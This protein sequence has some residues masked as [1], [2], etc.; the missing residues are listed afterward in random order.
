M[1]VL[2]WLIALLVVGAIGAWRALRARSRQR[3]LMLLCQ[4][5]GLRFSPVD[6]HGASAWMPFRW[7]LRG[8]WAG[9]ENVIAYDGDDVHA[10]DVLVEEWSSRDDVSPPQERYTCAV[11]PLE[12]G[13][14]RMLIRPHQTIDGLADAFTGAA[15]DLDLDAFNRRFTVR[16]DDR[17][18]AVAFCDQRMMHAIMRVPAGIGVATNEDRMLLFGAELKPAQMLLLLEAARKIRDAV[19]PVVVDL[20]PPRPPKS[21]Y[22]DR[23][24]QGRWSPDPVSRDDTGA[25]RR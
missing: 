22:E 4:R 13:C 6:L 16:A 25:S 21:P 11:V 20:Y 9:A 12:S 10:F 3:S 19:P 24:L 5:A 18:F 14:P 15:I 8:N 7:V 1:E 2:L 23:W 17:R